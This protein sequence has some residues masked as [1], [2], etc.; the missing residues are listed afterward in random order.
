MNHICNFRSEIHE[1]ILVVLHSGTDYDYHF[2]VKE[3]GEEFKDNF[4][5]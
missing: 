3:L 4:S 1:E 5:V 2:I